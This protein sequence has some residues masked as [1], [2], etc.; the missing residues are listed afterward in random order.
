MTR[1]F[2]YLQS[3]LELQMCR[4]RFC[5]SRNFLWP[6]Y[7][8]CLALCEMPHCVKQ[9]LSTGLAF[10][11][12]FWCAFYSIWK[13]L[14]ILEVRWHLQKL[15]IR[16]LCTI[17]NQSFY[18]YRLELSWIGNFL[19]Q[20]DQLELP[21][22]SG[23]PERKIRIVVITTVVYPNLTCIVCPGRKQSK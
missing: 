12:V 17:F 10:G 21:L 6:W 8:M 4:D 20:I 11:M 23:F 5:H 3:E 19:V 7:F 13:S 16:L 15:H 18:S 22:I 14:C 1:N 9:L 2:W